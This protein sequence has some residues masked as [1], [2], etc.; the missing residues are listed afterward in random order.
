MTVFQRILRY[1]LLWITLFLILCVIS[2]VRYWD[3]FKRIMLSTLDYDFSLV[4]MICL[5][6]GLLFWG[7]RSMFRAIVR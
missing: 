3:D 5:L 6:L 4:I 7:Y 2:V 1:L